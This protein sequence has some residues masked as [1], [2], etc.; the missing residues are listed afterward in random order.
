MKQ[1][2]L[3]LLLFLCLVLPVDGQN[4][5]SNGSFEDM[6]ACPTGSGQIYFVPGWSSSKGSPDYYNSCANLD[7]PYVGVPSNSLGFQNA[8]SGDAYVGIICFANGVFAREIVTNSLTSPLD[9]GQEYFFNFKVTRGDGAAVGQSSNNLGIHLSTVI[10]ENVSIENS[11]LYTSNTIVSDTMEWTTISGSFV[12]D[13]SYQYMMI[14]NFYDDINTS[15]VSDGPGP[16]AYYFIDD[17]CLSTDSLF[18]ANFYT[19][20]QENGFQEQFSIYPNPATDF[21]TIQNRSNVLFDLELYNSTGQLLHAERALALGKHQLE[22]KQH[23]NGL[24]FLKI[25]SADNQLTYKLL[26]R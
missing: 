14:G 4:L 23:T 24:I 6:V 11:S 1:S 25:I 8:A 9:I 13:S 20:T 22:I 17:V 5:V 12:A 21:I 19:S 3:L 18:C 15:V 26:K 2:T 16:W 7:T 10:E